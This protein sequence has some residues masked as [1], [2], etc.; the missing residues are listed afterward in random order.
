VIDAPL[1]YA[2]SAGMVAAV[3]PCGF[4][5]LPAYLSFFIGA[6]DESTDRASRIPRALASAAAVSLG[7]FVVFV[8]VGLPIDAGVDVLMEGVPWL[9][10]AIGAALV[11]FGISLLVGRGPRFTLPRLD[12][13]GRTRRFGSMV[14]FGMSYAIASLGCTLPIFLIAVA[15][16]TERANLLSGVSAFLAYAAGMSVVLLFVSLALALAR[17]GMVRRLRSVLR[18]ID[19]IAGALLVVVGVYLTYYGYIA[20]RDDAVESSAVSWVDD[21]SSELT[22]RLENGGV[23]LGLVLA[24]TVLG[25]LVWSYANR[26]GSDSD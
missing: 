8:G 14:L 16:T 15:G 11:A 1:A 18:Y 10:M 19:L 6:D 5:M 21:I 20:L 4:P 22:A 3:N 24:A 9:T 17:E 7:F 25:A 12:K 2:F 23:E 13:G 26:R